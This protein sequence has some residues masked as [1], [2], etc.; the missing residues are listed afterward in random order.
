MV[1]YAQRLRHC[2]VSYEQKL[3]GLKQ[4]E[5]EQRRIM[6]ADEPFAPADEKIRPEAGESASMPSQRGLVRLGATVFP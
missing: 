3:D 2:V 5:T 6:D 1:Q 4:W